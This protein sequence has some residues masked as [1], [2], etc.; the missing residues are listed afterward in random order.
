MS[1]ED[2]KL[3]PTSS[4]VK[5]Q[6]QSVDYEKS[7]GK[8]LK[9]AREDLGLT[10]QQ[11]ADRLHL[12]LNSVKAV[13]DD[14]LEPGV[15][16]IFSKGYVRL[17]AKLVYLEVQPLLDAYEKIN[18]RNNQPA[19]LQSFSKRVS[20]EADDH[21]W[22]MVT[23]VVVLLVLGSVIGWWVQQSDSLTTSQRFVSQTLD[24]LFS[25]SEQSED[26]AST[27]SSETDSI[28]KKESVLGLN[29]EQQDIARLNTGPEI[30]EED[31]DNNAS[32]ITN[33]SENEDSEQG[34]DANAEVLDP[35]G[36]AEQT[37]QTNNEAKQLQTAVPNI[38]NISPAA[39]TKVVNGVRMNAD[40]SINMAFAFKTDCWVSVKDVNNEIIAIGIKK[41]GRVMEVSGLAPIEITLCTPENVDIDFG[42][43]AI[44]MSVYPSGRA[45]NFTLTVES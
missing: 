23:V 37:D 27:R 33:V 38:V 36:Q 35:T 8:Q 19:K 6:T 7:P 14:A 34:L 16:L 9:K 41:Q 32:N 26:G 21:K 28:G 5:A 43:K 17:Y 24:K 39:T 44:D 40:G 18:S 42:G 13:E 15:S 30:P 10:Q 2:K 31:I 4:S 25:E 1:D 20:R 29:S 11:V 45:A 3:P 12:R 22:N